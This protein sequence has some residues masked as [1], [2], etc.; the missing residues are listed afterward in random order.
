MAPVTNRQRVRRLR[1]AVDE[2]HNALA[3]ALG[4]DPEG[5]DNVDLWITDP[6]AAQEARIAITMARRGQLRN[7]NGNGGES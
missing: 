6:G 3:V 7:G 4:L 1:I 2:L 5:G